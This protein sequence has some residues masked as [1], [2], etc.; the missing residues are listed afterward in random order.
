MKEGRYNTDDIAE[1]QLQ[2]GSNGLVLKNLIGVNRKRV[3]DAHEAARLFE[4][5]M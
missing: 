2:S 3:M 1:A 5:A 4:A